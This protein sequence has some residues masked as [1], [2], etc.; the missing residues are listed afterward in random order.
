VLGGGIDHH[1][2][3]LAHV[4]FEEVI[5]ALFFHETGE[6]V[7]IGFPVL[8]AILPWRVAADIHAKVGDFLLRED[9]FDNIGH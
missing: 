6:E 9:L 8:D 7:Q 4:M 5:D 3:M 2:G 1:Q